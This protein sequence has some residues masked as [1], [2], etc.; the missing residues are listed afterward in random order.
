VQ[1]L[2]R[3]SLILTVLLMP[4][5]MAPAQAVAPS[6]H[7]AAMPMPHC[8]DQQHKPAKGGIAECTMACA[9]ALPAIGAASSKPFRIV[10]VPERPAAAQRL[11]GLHPDTATP[12][13]RRS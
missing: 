10:C 3:L 7:A 8:P 6:H 2:A 4:L 9:A 5:G 13:P 11:D 1:F 12:P